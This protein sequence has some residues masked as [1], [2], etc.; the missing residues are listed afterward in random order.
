MNN[1]A[2]ALSN[3]SS[4]ARGLSAP[5]QH[6]R[7]TR[8]SNGPNPASAPAEVKLLDI[9]Q[10]HA[11]LLPELLSAC[12]RVIASGHMILG[13]EVAAL[14]QEM[15][16][17]CGTEFAVG[18]AS[19]SDALLLALMALG[20]G[21]GDEVIVPSFTFFATASAVWRLGATPVFADVD[22]QSF[23][24][25]VESI[26][27]CLT[28]RTRAIIPV[29]LYGQTADM[30]CI[31]DLAQ[32]Y[33]LRVIE[34]LAQAV[35]ARYAD[36]PAGSWGDM[37]CLSF[38]PTKNLGGFGDG[39]MVTTRSAELA[40]RLNI[41]RGHG[42]RPRYYHAEVGINSRLDELQAAL[43]RVKLAHLPNLTQQRQIN[44]RR[45][46]QLLQD[47]HLE[48]YLG[49]PTTSDPARHVWNQYTIR[50]LDERRDELREYLA[51]RGVGSE[52][53]YPLPLHQQECF[54]SLG[55]QPGS[56]PITETIARQVLSLPVHPLLSADD[57][58]HVVDAIS[59]FFTG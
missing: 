26:E 44:A 5:L 40:D 53:Y 56:L 32:N 55:Y 38:Y 13:P 12:Q 23:N 11:S 2:T 22:P 20:V 51:V 16:A 17:I 30:K 35:G 28:P 42:M 1:E 9:A 34:D 7:E 58:A 19:G 4:S 39:G 41:L 36:R 43:L 54:A 52:V 25:S 31:N 15:A 37:G 18:C 45:Y 50:V 29:H 47:A 10:E 27:P 59:R 6:P 14:E 21:A 3:P 33:D 49:L 57:Q 48:A 46:Q 24:I 8:N